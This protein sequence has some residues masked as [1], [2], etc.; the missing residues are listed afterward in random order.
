[1]FVQLEHHRSQYENSIAGKEYRYTR[2]RKGS[3][4]SKVSI[5]GSVGSV[6]TLETEI[7]ASQAGRFKIPGEVSCLASLGPNSI[8]KKILAKI[9]AKILTKILAKIHF[10]PGFL[11]EPFL[12][13]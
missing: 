2:T 3:P 11:P 12:V 5:L 4:G 13:N 9:L 1:M 6:G 10:L 8:G 7:Q